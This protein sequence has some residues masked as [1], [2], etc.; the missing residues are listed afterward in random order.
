MRELTAG[1]RTVPWTA[2][3][4]ISKRP[5]AM[6][7]AGDPQCLGAHDPARRTRRPEQRHGDGRVPARRRAAKGSPAQ[8][9]RLP[10]NNPL[11]PITSS[12]L[13]AAS[14]WPGFAAGAA[15]LGRRRAGYPFQRRSRIL[16]HVAAHHSDDRRRVRRRAGRV[17]R[18]S[19]NL[20]GIFATST[21]CGRSATI[22]STSRWPTCGT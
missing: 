7:R 2:W 17:G 18:A 15:V 16:A 8:S 11:N 12:L 21:P 5:S 13:S 22:S 9:G 14:R 6:S 3:R 10:M 20:T 4:R 19:S 1:S